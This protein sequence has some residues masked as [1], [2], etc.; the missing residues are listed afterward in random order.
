MSD[1]SPSK[2]GLP[3]PAK[4]GDRGSIRV[5]PENVEYWYLEGNPEENRTASNR[6][7]PLWLFGGSRVRKAGRR[8]I[9]QLEIVHVTKNHPVMCGN[10]STCHRVLRMGTDHVSSL[11]SSAVGR[12][13]TFDIRFREEHGEF[14]LSP[15]VFCSRETR[16]IGILNMTYSCRVWLAMIC[17][18]RER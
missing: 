8:T 4:T 3:A 2:H 16:F 13:H 11:K 10:A 6:K 1:G 14:K 18:G 5:H 9:A 12:Q 7:M 17:T 15:V